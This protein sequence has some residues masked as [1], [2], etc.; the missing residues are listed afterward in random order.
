MHYISEDKAKYTQ[1][2]TAS[3]WPLNQH[4]R[5]ILVNCYVVIDEHGHHTILPI[6]FSGLIKATS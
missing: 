5:T 4:S 1:L 6:C 2:L 3:R